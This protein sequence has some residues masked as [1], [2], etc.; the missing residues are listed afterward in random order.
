MALQLSLMA[1]FLFSDEAHCFCPFLA[2]ELVVEVAKATLC[3]EN[4]PGTYFLLQAHDLLPCGMWRTDRV[5]FIPSVSLL[6]RTRSELDMC[7][8]GP[9]QTRG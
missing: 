8:P 2:C 3:G 5:C 1:M 9:N 4:V 6:A 7:P